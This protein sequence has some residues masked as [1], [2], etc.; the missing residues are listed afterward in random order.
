MKLFKTVDERFEE[1]GYEKISEHQY[2]SVKYK[3]KL[4]NGY[5]QTLTISYG[6]GGE[7]STIKSIGQTNNAITVYEMKLCIKKIKQ[8]GWKMK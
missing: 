6:F 4:E 8:M 2:Q 1:I 7:H 3:R 5:S